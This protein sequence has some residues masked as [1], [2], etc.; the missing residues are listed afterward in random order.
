MKILEGLGGWFVLFSVLLTKEESQEPLVCVTS[1]NCTFSIR[2][3]IISLFFLK[4]LFIRQRES[5]QAGGGGEGE[6]EAGSLLNREPALGPG[7]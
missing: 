3:Q 4:I 1:M 6:G 5:A 7:S 2:V